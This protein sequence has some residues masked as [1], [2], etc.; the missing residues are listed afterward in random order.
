MVQS[1]PETA[2]ET[3]WA[4]LLSCFHFLSR[5][6]WEFFLP[7]PLALAASALRLSRRSVSQLS[8]FRGPLGLGAAERT[9]LV[10]KKILG[11]L[12]L[13]LNWEEI[14]WCIS[15]KVPTRTWPPTAPKLDSFLLPSA[16]L[17]MKPAWATY[18]TTWNPSSFTKSFSSKCVC[19]IFMFIT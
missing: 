11:V 4:Q 18:W 1:L 3:G 7:Y 10:G 2:R 12:F 17:P 6:W 14:G 19:F 5:H 8:K 16:F 13:V 15:K 9:N